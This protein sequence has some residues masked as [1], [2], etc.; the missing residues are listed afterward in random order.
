MKFKLGTPP[1]II[2]KSKASIHSSNNSFN[3]SFLFIFTENVDLIDT[4][5]SYSNSK[6]N[7][8]KNVFFANSQN[9]KGVR[10]VK[11]SSSTF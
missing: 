1:K 5:F 4:D 11:N 6:R 8:N 3:K 10:Y 9:S 7:K 2:F